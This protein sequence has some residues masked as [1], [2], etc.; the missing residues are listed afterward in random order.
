MNSKVS[1]KGIPE[2]IFGSLDRSN[3]YIDLRLP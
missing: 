3:F 1:Q 2:F